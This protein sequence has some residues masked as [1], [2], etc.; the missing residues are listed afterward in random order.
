MKLFVERF[1]MKTVL[2]M[3]LTSLSLFAQE[4]GPAE[5]PVP[6]PSFSLMD[7][8]FIAIMIVAFLVMQFV[9]VGPQKKKEK[10]LAAKK[11]SLQKGAEVVT[12]GGICGTVKK[13]TDD[14]VTLILDKNST[15]TIVKS[16]I[17][18]VLESDD[19]TSTT[20]KKDA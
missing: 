14:K 20:E 6:A 15:V 2:V 19:T 10:A 12:I 11:E 4:Q 5:A 7:P 1:I 16:A 8:S 18:S 13:V 3:F 9:I 17:G